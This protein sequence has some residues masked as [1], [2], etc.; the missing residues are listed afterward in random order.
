[1]TSEVLAGVV[2][3]FARDPSLVLWDLADILLVAVVLYSMLLLIRGTRAMQMGVGLALVF[4]VY[5]GAKRLGLVTLFEMLDTLLTSLVLIIVVVFQHDIR[6]ALVRFGRRPLWALRGSQENH[7][8]DEVVKAATSLAQKRIG[9]L[10]VFERDASLD[11]FIDEGTVLDA[12]ISKELLYSIFIP[13]FENPMH[14][15]ALI[16]REGR[17]W[18]A[19]AFLPLTANPKLDRSLGTRHRA[20]IGLSEETDAVVVVVSEERGAVSLC[21]NG[22]MVR[23]L[24][25]ASM[26]KV[27]LEL[28]N[29]PVKRRPSKAESEARDRLGQTRES[30][31][32]PRPRDSQPGQSSPGQSHATPSSS[33]ATPSPGATGEPPLPPER[34]SAK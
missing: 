13:S 1:M 7:S 22:N 5:Q 3:F 28:L 20:A 29:R 8:V 9:A 27:L 17:V 30:H 18:Q 16:L 25:G 32:P 23:N 2:D 15:G 21:F 10:I 12:A 14:D 4:I 26:R 24:D 6:R 33:H 11:D 34:E 31:P 19:G